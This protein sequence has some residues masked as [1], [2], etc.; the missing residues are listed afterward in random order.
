MILVFNFNDFKKSFDF[1]G[2][3]SKEKKL[4]VP[5]APAKILTRAL[6]VK[7]FCIRNKKP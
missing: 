3:N 7:D 5:N 1:Q 2:H 4:N 6:Q